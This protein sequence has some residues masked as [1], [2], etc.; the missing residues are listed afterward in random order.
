MGGCN[1]KL[2]LEDA[3]VSFHNFSNCAVVE[4][5]RGLKFK[6]AWVQTVSAPQD[7]SGGASPSRS[8][9]SQGSTAQEYVVSVKSLELKNTG[10]QAVVTAQPPPGGAGG[11]QPE[12]SSTGQGY[13]ITGTIRTAGGSSTDG[14]AVLLVSKVLNKYK[15]VKWATDLDPAGKKNLQ[16][17]AG[18]LPTI[19]YR[20]RCS[21]DG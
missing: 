17:L 5:F 14:V 21:W 4:D 12:N 1:R 15:V 19:P 11:G 13:V 7:Y 18:K 3:Q 6:D 20:G 2:T 16:E 8:G 9:D 10:A